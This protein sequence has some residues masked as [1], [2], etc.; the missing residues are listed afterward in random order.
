MGCH[1]ELSRVRTTRTSTATAGGAFA[2]GGG[3]GWSHSWGGG[4]AVHCAA[5]GCMV[6]ARAPCDPYG[7]AC[8]AALRPPLAPPP[9]YL[10]KTKLYLT[11]RRERFARC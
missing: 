7:A 1:A 4:F 2:C 10:D 6:A 5:A 8:T 9:D 11:A 3:S